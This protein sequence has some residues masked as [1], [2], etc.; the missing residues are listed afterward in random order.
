MFIRAENVGCKPAVSLL[1]NWKLT[2]SVQKPTMITADPKPFLSRN[3][4]YKYVYNSMINRYYSHI[5]DY[6]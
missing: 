2:S 5:F 1:G 4:I 6:I 3:F